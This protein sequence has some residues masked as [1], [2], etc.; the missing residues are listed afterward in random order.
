MY[1]STDNLGEGPQKGLTP[2]KEEQTEGYTP[3]HA[4]GFG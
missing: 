3:R 4:A 1:I 2:T